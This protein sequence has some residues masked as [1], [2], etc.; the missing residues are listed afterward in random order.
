MPDPMTRQT[1]LELTRRLIERP[2]VSPNDEGCQEILF[3]QLS[4]EGFERQQL[5]FEDVR[6]LWAIKRGAHPGPTLI[7]AGHTDVVPPGPLAEWTHHPFKLTVVD[8]IIYGRGAA[9]M[10]GALAAMTIAAKTF[11][12]DYPEF[13]GSLGFLITSDEEAIATHGTKLA[14][15][16]LVD[17]GIK[18]DYAIVGEPSSSQ[19]LGDT[20]RVGRRGSLNGRLRVKGQ[21]G[22]V[23]YPESVVNPIHLAARALSNLCDRPLDEGHGAFP[24]STLQVTNIHAGTGAT[25]VVPGDCEIDFNFRYNT[26]WNADRLM[27]WTQDALSTTLDEFELS[28]AI[29][30]EPFLTGEGPLLDVVDA[31]I[32]KVCGQAP[33]HSTGGGTSDG[34]FLAPYGID[35]V[36]LGVTNSSIHKID[37][38]VR[39]TE[40]MGLI[41]LYYEIM[42]SLL[43]HP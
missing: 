27:T 4:R 38:H 39:V 28:W 8:D 6:N 41:D 31:A 12:T 25:N 24:P 18:V 26:A 40:L 15:K 30:G 42:R 2:S 36:E 43:V 23:A 16:A 37:E 35:V 20:I 3:D 5:D 10:K 32:L 17:S 13:N 34:R 19:V 22:H 14:I 9:D 29:S 1:L 11:L 33:V 7:F 21:Q